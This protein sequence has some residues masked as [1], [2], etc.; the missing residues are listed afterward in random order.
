LIVAIVALTIGILAVTFIAGMA[1]T[2]DS[3]NSASSASPAATTST[4]R[5]STTTTEPN[6]SPT[7]QPPASPGSP[8][9]GSIDEA[10]LET[11]VD[12]L[13]S[14]VERERGHTFKNDVDITVMKPT[15]FQARV[16][17]VFESETEN[18]ER[19][20][21]LLKALGLIPPELDV[22]ATQRKLLS[23]GV[24]G[25]YDPA[26]DQLVVG[27]DGIGPF[28]RVVLVHELTHALDD[29]Y[30]DLDRPA[31]DEATDGSDWSFLALAEGSAKRV[32]NAYVDQLS[33][34]D[35]RDLKDEQLAVGM[36]QLDALI[37]TPMVLARIQ[38]T[39]YDYGEPFV[40]ELVEKHGI[41]GLDAAFGAPPTTSEQVL[42][43]DKFDARE[44]A[45]DV[46]VPG[47]DGTPVDDGVLG[48]LMTGILL[49]GND[50]PLG[51][52]SLSQEEMEDLVDRIMKG[53]ITPEEIEEIL[54]GGSGIGG[55]VGPPLG[56][57]ELGA[58]DTVE[59]WGGDRY[60]L[61]H[62]E[63][64]GVC[65]RVAWKMDTTTN[66]QFMKAALESWARGDSG[67]PS[68]EQPAP[69]V[70]QII[71]CSGPAANRSRPT[72]PTT[73]N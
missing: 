14:F 32:E 16:L 41:E 22:V 35:T 21:D 25:Y 7:T 67:R 27:G 26:S 55:P 17:E 3:S 33:A 71:R 5:R 28:L 36:Q 63:T 64:S 45:I 73:I 54:G 6:A 51:L 44:P 42:H 69:D 70:I 4:T 43:N 9:T 62:S 30:F 66:L 52:G 49:H 65:A 56:S 31:V 2:R 18:M 68:V 13:K 15:D 58:I 47:T 53:E 23:T 34:A 19:E 40:R 57:S 59:G 8:S 24:L 38:L 20:G 60:V 48:E 39:P 10:Q 29:Q 12:A 1:V 50:S 11:E 61:W 37:G 46:A 72:T